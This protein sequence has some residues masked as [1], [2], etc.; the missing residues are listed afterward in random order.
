MR[1]A[2]LLHTRLGTAGAQDEKAPA[3]QDKRQKAKLDHPDG[4]DRP[5]GTAPLFCYT[6]KVSRQLLRLFKH[7]FLKSASPGLYERELR[8]LL[9]AYL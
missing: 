4:A 9:Q 8:P 1:V 5:E 2:L 3:K 6:A 7:C